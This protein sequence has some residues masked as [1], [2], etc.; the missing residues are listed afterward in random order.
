MRKSK[1]FDP[2]KVRPEDYRN[3]YPE[4]KRISEFELLSATELICIW[5]YANPTSDIIGVENDM[6]RMSEALKLSNYTPPKAIIND[7]L[8]LRFPEKFAIA[9]DRM[10]R[11]EPDIRMKARIMVEKII[12]SYEGMC[13]PQNFK[14]D[15]NDIDRKKYVET[16]VKIAQELP[17]LIAKLEEGFGVSELSDDESEQGTAFNRDWYINKENKI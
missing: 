4:L 2:F 5:Y 1:I 16:T 7:I 3:R 15:N 9:I 17:T 10:K 11:F 14:D 13:D 6:E 8:T 12:G